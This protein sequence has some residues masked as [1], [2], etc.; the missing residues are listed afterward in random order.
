M[1]R[2]LSN[3]FLTLLLAS[4]ASTG[5]LAQDRAV[6]EAVTRY[7]DQIIELRQ[8]SPP[9]PGTGEPGIRDRRAGR[10]ASP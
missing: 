9:E 6:D 5:V 4:V 7:A 2:S 8:R 1:Q 10:G 3:T